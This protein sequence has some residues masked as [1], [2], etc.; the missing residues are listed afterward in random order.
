ME[1]TFMEKKCCTSSRIC[2]PAL[3]MGFGIASGLMMMILAWV[4]W[5]WGF[6]TAVVDQYGSFYYGYAATLTGGFFGLL[7]G[8]VEG[9]VFGLITGWIYN[10]VARCCACMKSCCGGKSCGCGA[11]SCGCGTKSCS[12]GNTPCTCN[13]QAK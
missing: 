10:C 13:I 1:S 11:K 3:G 7:W 9:F 6:G 2:S 8:F 12:C 5:Q 4:A